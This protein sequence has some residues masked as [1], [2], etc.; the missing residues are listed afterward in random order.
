M[1]RILIADDHA[2]IRRGLRQMFE[3]EK[4]IEIIADA[5]NA[6][7]VIEILRKKPCD[8]ILLDMT[9]PKKHGLELLDELKHE[10]PELKVLVLSMHPE[11]H[12][13]IRALKAGASGYLTKDSDPDNIIKA[14]R[15]IASGGKYISPTLAEMIE[16][17]LHHKSI[18]Q[19]HEILSTREFAVF[20]SLAKGKTPNDIAD[21]LSLSVKT[22]NNY[23]LRAI[24]KMRLK[25]NADI[26]NYAH[27]NNL[28]S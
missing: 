15:K 13:G 2:I 28:V 3:D 22:V 19:P 6:V 18:Q 10:F 4:D 27:R 25:S 16:L 8:I 1:I 5:S 24:Q 21:E 9:M 7:D 11:E 23:R 12:F 26:I 14:I 20:L 17:Q